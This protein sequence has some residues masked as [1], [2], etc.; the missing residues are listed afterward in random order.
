VA[1][2][3]VVMGQR[4]KILYVHA[5]AALTAY[6]A[7]GVTALG[8]VLYLRRRERRFDRLAV[9][10]AELGVVLTSATLA[11]G[12]LW[13]RAVQGWWWVWEPRL[14]I[15]LLL[16][17]LYV[18][19]L[20]LRQYTEGEQRARLSAALAVAGLPAMVLNHFA[21]ELLRGLHPEPVFFRPGGAAADPAMVAILAVCTVAYLLVF[22]YLLARRVR[23]EALRD[24][25]A[26]REPAGEAVDTFVGGLL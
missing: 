2:P 10:S 5:S 6:L 15:T 18:G 4:Q 11:T 13:G 3:E 12:S 23:L 16:W 20:V 22:A 21:T 8:A 19:Y 9:A 26:R 14:T 25:L 1:P 24:E 7:Y 17:F